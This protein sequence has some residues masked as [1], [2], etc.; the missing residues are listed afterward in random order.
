MVIARLSVSWIWLYQASAPGPI[1]DA[2]ES[3][4][5]VTYEQFIELRTALTALWSETPEA[6]LQALFID[7]V[8]ES[9][10]ALMASGYKDSA[11]DHTVLANHLNTLKSDPETGGW[12]NA[13][14]IASLHERAHRLPPMPN[15]ESVP[16]WL[17]G[18]F[19]SF[20]SPHRF[21]SAMAVKPMHILIIWSAGFRYFWSTLKGRV[22]LL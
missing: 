20:N 19:G 1:L 18:A 8:A 12:A 10:R 5:G 22:D 3:G 14:L 21:C 13:F 6:N 16:N 2:H 17:K 11:H 4:A 15:P 7:T 9:H